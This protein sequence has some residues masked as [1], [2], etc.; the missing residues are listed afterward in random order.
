[1]CLGVLHWAARVAPVEQQLYAKESREM[2]DLYSELSTLAEGDD[3]PECERIRARAADPVTGRAH[4]RPVGEELMSIHRSLSES[5][6]AT[7]DDVHALQT[8]GHPRGMELLARVRTHLAL[9]SHRDLEVYL[10]TGP[11]SAMVGRE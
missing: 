8:Q 11:T 10:G 7:L 3:A 5:L 4:A 9:R 1:M 2:A 6:V